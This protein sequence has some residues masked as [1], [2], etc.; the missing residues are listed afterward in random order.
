MNKEMYSRSAA[1]ASRR[2]RVQ[3]RRTLL[4]SL[5][6]IGVLSVGGT[7][8]WVV[9][10]SEEVENSFRPAVVQIG[11]D[12]TF[13]TTGSLVK[14]GVKITNTAHEADGTSAYVRAAVV[15]NWV[16][17]ETGAVCG[18]APEAGTD[19]S[20]DGTDKA[21]IYDGKEFYYYT[22]SIDPGESTSEL[23]GE[24]RQLTEKAGYKLHVDIVSSAIQS[25]PDKA[26]EEAW[27]NDVVAIDSSNGVLS[28]T[29]KN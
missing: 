23:I 22:S 8:A 17:E 20:M 12:E 6:L 3:K 9:A 15:V 4:A 28:V 19:Y 27:A 2:R 10:G 13:E 25:T 1:L 21:W 11:I 18:D 16:D 26:V 7:L 29:K 14:Q 5:A 24:C